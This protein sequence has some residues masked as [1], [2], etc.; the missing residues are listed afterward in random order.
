[1]AVEVLD[2][3]RPAQLPEEVV[4]E[5][6]NEQSS[7]RSSVQLKST[8]RESIAANSIKSEDMAITPPVL[9]DQPV[10]RYADEPE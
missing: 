5:N 4:L 9:K 1:M 3:T 6:K 2:S 7:Q 10:D 8:K